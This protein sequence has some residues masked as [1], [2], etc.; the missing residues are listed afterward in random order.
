MVM[1]LRTKP[2]GGKGLFLFHTR[3]M[4][5]EVSLSNKDFAI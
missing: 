4:M 1:E 5:G 3:E 2:G